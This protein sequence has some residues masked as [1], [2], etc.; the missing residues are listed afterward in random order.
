MQ[1]LKKYSI[2][3]V[4]PYLYEIAFLHESFANENGLSECYERLEFLGDAVMDLVISEFLYNSDSNLTEGQLTH[5]RANYVCKNA[6]YTYSTELGLDQYIKYGAGAELTRRE[7]DSVI[8]DVFESFIGALYLDQGLDAVQ[9]FLLKTVIPHIKNGDI[10][11]YDYKSELKQFCDRD[12]LK[13]SYELIKEEGEPHEKTFTM[14]VIIEGKNCGA[15]SG[16]SKKEAEQSAARIGLS[17]F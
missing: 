2:E 15:G 17:R 3:P 12:G 7:T 11:F 13:L 9:E 4:N 16:R 14:A 1:L 10:F 8:S 5:M 6:L